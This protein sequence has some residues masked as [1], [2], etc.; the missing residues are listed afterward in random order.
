MPDFPAFYMHGCFCQGAVCVCI[1]VLFC[2]GVQTDAFEC[3][4]ERPTDAPHPQQPDPIHV[5][6]AHTTQA[7]QY[8]WLQ[9]DYPGLFERIKERASEGRFVPVG[10]SWVEMDTNLVG[11][12]DVTLYASAT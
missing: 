3:R 10:G 8:E 7:Q 4:Q 1:Y 9:E 12:E 2:G 5:C 11:G 6:T